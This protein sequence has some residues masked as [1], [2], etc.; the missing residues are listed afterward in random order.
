PAGAFLWRYP[1]LVPT[2]H[3]NPLLERLWQAGVFEATRWYPS[4]QPMRRA[5]APALPNA[6]TPVADALAQQ[7]INLPLTPETDNVRVDE[8]A[9]IIC[10]YVETL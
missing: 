5:L 10:E 7:I 2:E 6:P 9:R 1:V 4:L 3:R 8:I